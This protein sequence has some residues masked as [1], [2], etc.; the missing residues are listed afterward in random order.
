MST[1][2]SSLLEAA[3][4][5]AARG[6]KVFAVHG[7]DTDGRC[8]CG[9]S[10][11]DSPGKH[12]RT[13]HGLRDATT[14]EDTIRATWD[15]WPDANVAINMG[16]SGLV[17]IDVDVKSGALGAETW[18]AVK[19]Q[20]GS[21]IEGTTIVKTPSGGCHCW[22]RINGHRVGCDT[23]GKLIGPGV[24]VK[25]EGGYLLVPPSSFAGT[26]YV[27]VEGHGPER[28]A[29][30]PAALAERLSFAKRRNGGKPTSASEEI[31]EGQRNS[32]LAGLALALRRTGM[33]EAEICA[34]L[35]VTNRTRCRPPLPER[36]VHGIATRY[37]TYSPEPAST[38]PFKLTELGN[39]ERM[40]TR[41][42]TRIAAVRGQGLKG[43]DPRRGIFTSEH[44]V[45][46][47]YAKDTVRSM[48]TE[49][50]ECAEEAPRK[51]LAEHARRSESKRTLD[52]MLAL[53]E[54][55]ES[56]ET[57][58]AD[59]DAN[60]ELLNVRNG[61][62]DLRSGALHDDSPDYRMTRIAGAKYDL[63]APRPVWNAHLKRIFAGD[64]ETIAFMQRLYGYGLTGHTGEQVFVINCGDGA[65]GKAQL[66]NAWCEAAGDYAQPTQITTFTPH[67]NDA[68]RND[69]AA[70]AG[71]RLVTASEARVRQT[72]DTPLVK[73]LT[74]NDPIT[75]RFLHREFFTFVPQ[76]LIVMS[77][78]H[79][80]K[81]ECPD[82]AIK[83]RIL[84]VPFEVIIPETERDPYFGAK[85]RA[86][87]DGILTWGIEGAA[88]YLAHGLRVPERVRAA[89]EAYR[90][91]MDPLFGFRDR[92][93][94]EP[95]AW[96]STADIRS[97][98]RAWAAEEH[99]RDLPDNNE[100]AAFLT[101][102]GC[103]PERHGKGRERGWRGIRV[104]GA[105]AAQSFGEE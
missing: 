92:C 18:H 70:L 7:T 72:L 16:A 54:S 71:A 13:E 84:L 27:F 57:E 56:L 42:R 62:V 9:R 40:A 93:T 10:D 33:T 23:R 97:A 25:G 81:I 69:L 90:E 66:M 101:Q 86:E 47:R 31:P 29:D 88:D 77:T 17:G 63:S 58:A 99:V 19:A 89:T 5:Y 78:N 74:G 68:I 50:A 43:Y 53:A 32:T 44:A 79:K 1:Q 2:T 49:A 46:V 98:L 35:Q 83:R 34:A 64:A 14:D 94:F 104:E 30:L 48:Y 41:H 3:L 61:V 28:L 59:F 26:E 36:D 21:E 76:F 24:D 15:R 103:V 96:T 95:T 80:P 8:S 20:L 73:Q 67:R 55:E 6:I 12:P 105:D 87:L 65:N 100:L 39:A 38:E 37:A 51:A 45:L 85:L 75:A 102:L 11:C 82:Y 60:P 52:A 91:E 22:Y 4:G